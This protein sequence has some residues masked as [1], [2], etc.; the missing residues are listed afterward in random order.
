MR[1]DEHLVGIEAMA[2]SGIRRSVHTKRVVDPRSTPADE[3]VP[4]VKRLVLKRIHPD[5]LCRFSRRSAFEQQEHH[6]GGS[7][8]EK[9]EV[10]PGGVGGNPQRGARFSVE[11]ERHG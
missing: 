4:E 7:L 3:H 1:A 6:F 5:D 9:R 11:R 8:G 2:R 10:D